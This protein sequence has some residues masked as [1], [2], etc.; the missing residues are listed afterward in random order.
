MNVAG[1]DSVLSPQSPVLEGRAAVPAWKKTLRRLWKV[2]IGTLSGLVLLAVVLVA[3]FAEAIAPHDPLQGELLDRLQPPAWMEGGSREHLLGTD[4]TGRDTLSRLIYGARVSLAV[5]LLAML[6]SAAIGV[7][8]GLIAG[9]AG[10]YADTVISTLVNVMLTFPFIL[11]ALVV[12]AVLGPSFTNVI[13]VIGIASWTVYTRVIRADVQRL[14]ELDFVTAARCLGCRDT[15]ILLRHIL[16]NTFNTVIVLSTVQIARFIITEAFLSF[17]G[18]GIQPPTPA[19]GSMLGD[20]RQFMFDKWWLPTFP[21]LA[22]FITTLAINLFGDGLRD[23]LDPYS[24]N[25]S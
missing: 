3:V 12:I 11:L 24:R 23:W 9:Y 8:L 21:G 25:V 13:I 1:R 10:R 4:Q 5:G 2:R 15:R 18:L 7:S 17:L 16:P 14:R 22:I 20:S 19:W 6:V